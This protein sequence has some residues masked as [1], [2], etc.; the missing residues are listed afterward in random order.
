[1]QQKHE[2]L[3]VLVDEDD[4]EIGTMPKSE[5]HTADT[6]LHRAFSCFIFKDGN[7][8]LQQ[9]SGKKVTWPLMWSNSV[10]GH[11][12]PGEATEDAVKRRA[13]FELG[14]ELTSIQFA[15]PYRYR[16]EREGVV[17]NEVCPI[18][19]ATVKDEPN[20]NPDEV[21]ATTWIPWNEFLEEIK[22]N[23]EKYSEW[24]REEAMILEENGL[25]RDL[26]S[27]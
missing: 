15:A 1:M 2:E 27:D 16:F 8:L 13:A 10:C 18:Y 9:R 11:P 21:E 23:S 5:V 3:V 24:C 14:L 17:E 7:L 4:H 12:A 22:T 19:I 6:P 25:V 26:V 20:P